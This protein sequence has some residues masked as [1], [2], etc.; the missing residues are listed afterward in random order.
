MEFLCC[1]PHFFDPSM[2][3]KF[4]RMVTTRFLVLQLKSESFPLLLGHSLFYMIRM[5]RSPLPRT[6]EWLP[7]TIH[8]HIVCQIPETGRTWRL[9][10]VMASLSIQDLHSYRSI[11]SSFKRKQLNEGRA[12]GR[13]LW[14]DLEA[15]LRIKYEGRIGT[16]SY[17]STSA[18]GNAF[19]KLSKSLL[20][21]GRRPLIFADTSD[22][23]KFVIRTLESEGIDACTW[24]RIASDKVAGKASHSRNMVIVANKT[25]EGQGINMQHYADT[26]VC[27][28]TP[29][30]HL[31]QMKGR[32]DRPGQKEKKLY[33]YV[34]VCEHSI[35]EAKF[36]N[37]RL[38]GNFFREYIAPVAVRYKER[39]DLEATLAVSGAGKLKQG[40]VSGAWRREL[41]AAGQSGAFAS[42]CETSS[43]VDQCKF[44]TMEKDSDLEGTGGNI[45]HSVPTGE[46]EEKYKPCNTV[47]RNRGDPKA[48]AEAK[49]RARNGGVSNAV[50]KWLFPSKS[51]AE[52]CNTVGEKV[53]KTKPLPM[54]SLLRFSNQKPALVL[55]ADTVR[56]AVVHLS[57]NDPKLAALIARVGADA[58][59]SDCGTPRPPTQ[60]R[61]FD[62]CVRGITFTMVSVDAGNSFLRRLAMKVGTILETIPAPRRNEILLQF[63]KDLRESG[64]VYSTPDD[65]LQALL[66][67]R[68]SEI[69]FTHQLV[70]ELV[71]RCVMLKGKR[72]GYPV[73]RLIRDAMPEFRRSQRQRNSP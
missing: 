4:H 40:T 15:F 31:E 38:A 1:L 48:V 66:D 6:M 10:G 72:S 59:I 20:R 37:I 50:Q 7:A 39:I 35:E 55:D 69:T 41:H 54:K 9:E 23:A 47:L 18:M 5:L 65:V 44:S 2:T 46:A 53:S 57:R 60:A 19:V 61:L 27:R 51:R 30:D 43:E 62:R 52:L 24:A 13:K 45:E 33:L 67:G 12:D 8:E 68:H 28:P 36:A 56:K 22:E 42:T 14:T 49:S 73:S 58:L 70:A 64:Q 17:S 21:K 26:I 71:N 29:G 11:V 25:V 16:K 3:R 32:I 63:L 34:V